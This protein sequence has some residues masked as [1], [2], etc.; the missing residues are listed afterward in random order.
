MLLIATNKYK[1]F[2]LPL[3]KSVD[4]HFFKNDKVEVV[5]FTDDINYFKALNDDLPER[6]GITLVEIP[7]YK[8]P[9]ATTLRYRIFAQNEQYI[10][11]EYCFYCDADMLFVD[12]VDKEILPTGK[13]TIVAVRHCGFYHGG[14]SW[15]TREEC[16]AYVP[17]NKRAHYYAGGIQA[18]ITFYYLLMA[19]ILANAIDADRAKGIE[20]VWNDESYWNA[21]LSI[22]PH[23]KV[24][25]PDYCMVEQEHLRKEWKVDNFQP[26]I[27]ALS[28][29]HK[30]IRQ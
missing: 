16:I 19:N 20:A 1:Q 17:E 3:L 14:G 2:I 4:K 10:K 11:S 28:K 7:P 8:F 26:K 22:Y 25:T 18:G 5:L 13:E 12:D 23:V 30:D 21:Y 27:I 29:N 24:L 6:L 15:E 9:D